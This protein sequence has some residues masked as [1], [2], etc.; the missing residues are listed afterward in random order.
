MSDFLTRIA[1]HKRAEIAAREARVPSR[2]V[3]ELA[4]A[5]AP[6]RDFHGALQGAAP[7]LIA[8][9]K[10]ASPAKGALNLDLRPAALAATY[11]A[12]G[13]H[14]LSVLTDGQFFKGHD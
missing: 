14:A 4:R 8:E 12:A 1:A 5:A 11:A 9:I 10:R 2:V 13:A 3:Q 7:R 6:P